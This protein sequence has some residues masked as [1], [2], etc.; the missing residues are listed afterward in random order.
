MGLDCCWIVLGTPTM[1]NTGTIS[2]NAPAMPLI[3]E[4]S[5]TP[6]LPVG[7]QVS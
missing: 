4:S 2:E 5:P 1:C 3:A 6:K 7:L